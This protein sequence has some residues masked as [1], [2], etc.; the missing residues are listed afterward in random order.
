MFSFWKME[1]NGNYAWGITLGGSDFD[2]ATSI[3][4]SD[5]LNVYLSGLFYRV[6]DFDL[7]L[8]NTTLSPTSSREAFIAKYSNPVNTALGELVDT[9][10]SILVNPNPTSQR[11]N[12]VL[13]DL[14]E[15]TLI[16][17]YSM[18]GAVDL[19]KRNDKPIQFN[20]Y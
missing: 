6:M 14:D 10:P 2:Q 4:V 18:E 12:I 9:S 13:N 17:I 11:V 5:S 19:K 20:F 15:N 8:G 3:E 1:E 16:A 7:S